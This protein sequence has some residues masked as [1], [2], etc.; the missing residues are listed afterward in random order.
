MLYAQI[1]KR[2]TLLSARSDAELLVFVVK[3]MDY[4]MANTPQKSAIL[5]ITR[6]MAATSS[7]IVN[8][9]GQTRESH[10]EKTPDDFLS[11][12]VL[13][14]R[15]LSHNS[16]LPLS[17]SA[18]SPTASDT[19]LSFYFSISPEHSIQ[20]T[21]ADSTERRDGE[22]HT[23]HKTSSSTSDEHIAQTI[24]HLATQNFPHNPSFSQAPFTTGPCQSR[25][26]THHEGATQAG[27]A[28]YLQWK[29]QWDE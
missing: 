25:R 1:L 15:N 9:I 14:F 2:T 26:V 4:Y 21:E 3:A 6:H 10:P 24:A 18:R 12:P 13:H 19:P 22:P 8:N 16:E 17:P 20:S 23:E 27:Q 5:V 28:S 7:R 11:S 29:K